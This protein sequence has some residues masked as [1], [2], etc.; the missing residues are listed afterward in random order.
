MIQETQNVSYSKSFIYIY[1][2]LQCYTFLVYNSKDTICLPKIELKTRMELLIN[3]AIQLFTASK[4]HLNLI[5]PTNNEVNLFKFLINYIS[6]N[7]R[8]NS[9]IVWGL[10]L[11][12][13]KE[14][15]EFIINKIW[16]SIKS[17]LA[18][19]N[20]M[21]DDK[22]FKTLLWL[23]LVEDAENSIESL[24]LLCQYFGIS[25]NDFNW[26]VENELHHLVLQSCT[27]SAKQ[28]SAIEKTFYR[29]EQLAQNCIESSMIFTR[30]VAEL[31][32]CN[33]L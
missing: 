14:L 26:N 27:N 29:Y 17:N 19:A 11:S 2:S 15:R 5:A 24:S 8:S 31:Q 7:Q 33:Y 18:S 10:Q 16:L 30:R 23:N 6:T 3:R 22:S 12:Q 25:K 21:N 9:F 28:Q 4:N 20:T 32:V 1:I 13:S